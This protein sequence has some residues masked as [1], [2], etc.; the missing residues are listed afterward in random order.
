MPDLSNRSDKM[1]FIAGSGEM[2]QRIQRFDW[3]KH[4][5]GPP[6][7]WPQSLRSAVGI[8]LQSAFPTAIYWGPELRLLYND[9]WAPIPG[10]RH[11]AALGKPAQEVWADIWDIIWPQFR[12]LLETGDGFFAENQLLP[13][14]RYGFEEETYWSY[15]FSA[16][17][18]EDGRIAGIFNCG[19]E[20][21]ETVLG[22]RRLAFMLDFSERLH[23][24]SEP[25]AATETA[26]AL[27]GRHLQAV[28]VGYCEA[29]DG[30]DLNLLHGWAAEGLP[31]APAG[32][33][34]SDFGPAVAR[35]LAKGQAVRI[36][37]VESYS[38]TAGPGPA[39]TFARL[40]S[41]AGVFV[42]WMQGDRLAAALFLLTAEPR[43]W[44]GSD[45]VTLQEAMET[46]HNTIVI[47]R[48]EERQALLMREIDHRA[49]NA[50]AVVQAVVHLSQAE[51]MDDFRR[52]VEDRIASLSRAHDLLAESRWQG[53]EL[54]NLIEQELRAFGGDG[55]RRVRLGG[56][57]LRL[58]PQL[59]QTVAL[60][61]HEL[62]TNAAK[63]GALKGN[64]GRL[65]VI[66]ENDGGRRLVLDWRETAAEPISPP[67]GRGGFG[68]ELL[69]KS[70]RGQLGGEIDFDWDPG[71]LKCRLVLPLQQ[72]DR[73]T[74]G[75]AARPGTP[76]ATPRSDA[77][78]GL[79][80][81]LLAEDEPLVA[82]D[83]E[84][85]L[86]GFGY[87]IVATVD[88]LTAALQ[89]AE[90][91]LPDV[92]LLD[93]NLHGESSLPAALVLTRRGVPVVFITGY[94]R[95]ENLPEELAGVPRLSKPILDATLRETLAA[96][97]SSGND[98]PDNADLD[99]RPINTA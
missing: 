86:E 54:R 19:Y 35:N 62:T 12:S 89:V 43:R 21:T 57:A 11:P 96:A 38:G 18:G 79:P 82:M 64:G 26:A 56:P 70:I 58:P 95:M 87:D 17:R 4:P 53:L 97:L 31:P 1:S 39:D 61:L 92:A 34:L 46:A 74:E 55:G 71:G 72:R 78:K 42:P 6:E 84:A 83:L 24:Q 80:R 32:L 29:D 73:G 47:L 91:D 15:S 50:L 48:N 45:V 67:S 14:R 75:A 52:V 90:D 13:M 59:A 2:A 9:A 98:R 41:R 22:Q 23:D 99:S 7:D 60:A 8:C 94:D 49:K 10:P 20:T 81:L 51:D 25:E 76:A 3:A 66:W 27:L 33:R 88:N 40:R 30:G 85:R 44:S 63:Y 77:A 37:D 36:D 16:I 69:N 68:S 65:D 5:F 28:H 93:A